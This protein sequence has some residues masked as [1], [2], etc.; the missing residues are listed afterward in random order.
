M[1]SDGSMSWTIWRIAGANCAASRGRAHHEEVRA[2][3]LLLDRVED[4]D[5]RR[6]IECRLM[7]AADDADDR[8]PVGLGVRHLVEGDSL[9][10][11]ILVRE[12]RLR[13]TLVDHDHV[14]AADAILGGEGAAT[15]HRHLHR[16]EVVARHAT[17][18]HFATVA[19]GG[20]I[21]GDEVA[22]VRNA[23]QGQAARVRRARDARQRARAIHELIPERIRQ[24]TRCH[25]CD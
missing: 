16:L 7:F 6:G 13:E 24:P 21:R 22:R 10:D 9:A 5:L 17:M 3:R 19:V 18:T 1:A 2:P 15:D 12:V 4:F 11:R 20:T 8:P 23:E 25:T 14:G